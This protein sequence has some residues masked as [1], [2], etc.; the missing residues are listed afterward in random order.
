MMYN[1]RWFGQRV[2]YYL[3][4]EPFQKMLQPLPEH[5][6]LEEVYQVVNSLVASSLWTIKDFKS[7]R[8]EIA[9]HSL[10]EVDAFG[11]LLL[12]FLSMPSDRLSSLFSSLDEMF[13]LHV[14]E[15]RVKIES[16]DE[17][18]GKKKTCFGIRKRPMQTGDV[19][20]I[21]MA[22]HSLILGSVYLAVFDPYFEEMRTQDPLENM[23]KCVEISETLCQRGGPVEDAFQDFLVDSFSFITDRSRFRDFVMSEIDFQLSQLQKTIRE[24]MVKESE[25]VGIEYVTYKNQVLSSYY[26][27]RAKELA[28]NQKRYASIGYQ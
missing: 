13:Q 18:T 4:A 2:G 25:R 14:L 8:K 21:P 28:R 10:T 19:V 5:S 20:R 16:I 23:K 7:F 24:Q 27:A 12:Y 1:H 17:E 15:E 26:S 11:P 6:C 9:V 22:L 3:P